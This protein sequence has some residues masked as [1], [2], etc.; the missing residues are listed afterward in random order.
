MALNNLLRNLLMSP[1]IATLATINHD[2]SPQLSEVWY[3]YTNEK[4]LITTTDVRVKTK[5]ILRDPRVSFAVST[6][7]PPYAGVEIRGIATEGHHRQ[8]DAI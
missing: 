1:N 8:V 3:E 2:G 4:I 7:E 5:N 6:S